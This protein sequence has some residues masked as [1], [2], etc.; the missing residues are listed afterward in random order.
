VSTTEILYSFV[1]FHST[2]CGWSCCAYPAQDDFYHR[3]CGKTVKGKR[4]DL[5]PVMAIPGEIGTIG[6]AAK[7]K[8]A[9]KLCLA[10]AAAFILLQFHYC[11]SGKLRSFAS[12][13]LA[14]IF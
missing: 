8:A 2:K 14:F 4:K 6:Q 11:F 10:I 1:F 12:V 9:A 7:R 3:F 5:D 13:S